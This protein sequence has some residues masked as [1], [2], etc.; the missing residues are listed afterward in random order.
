MIKKI[1]SALLFLL[2]Q[3]SFAQIKITDTSFLNPKIMVAQKYMQG[4]NSERKKAVEIYWQCAKQGSVKA[5]YWL[6]VI[7]KYAM[8]EEL[9]YKKSHECFRQSAEMNSSSGIYYTGYMLHKG[10]G[11]TQDYKKA[12]EYFKLG[13]NRGERGCMYLLG[14]SYRNGYGVSLNI[15]SARYWLIKSAE[16]GYNYAKE[17]LLEKKPEN[18]NTSVDLMQKIEAVKKIIGPKTNPINKYTKI[19]TS[20]NATDLEGTYKGYLVKYDW[21]GTH[22]I[23]VTSLSLKLNYRSKKIYGIWKEGDADSLTLPIQAILT[24]TDGLVFDSMQYR[25]ADHYNKKYPLRYI[26]KNAALQL[27]KANDTNYLVGNLDLFVPIF[28]EPEKPFRIVLIQTEKGTN[29]NNIDFVN[30][31]GSH[32][33][34]VEK[35]KV[36]PNPFTTIFNTEFTLRKSSKVYTQLI[37]ADGKIVYNTPVVTLPAG[38]YVLPLQPA[39]PKGQYFLRLFYDNQE[40][41]TQIIK[42]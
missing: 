21:S 17:E 31:D 12:C 1:N 19:E 20:V 41:N 5:W 24:K 8:V 27:F 25:K 28:Q 2:C 30:K 9:D 7:Y 42:L 32:I 4:T 36:Y 35:L 11:C 3:N 18:N 38:S 16:K 23:D 22:I 39:V 10:L 29:Q 26:F 37:T 6:G 15:D 13:A 34:I 40:Q 33:E 14:I